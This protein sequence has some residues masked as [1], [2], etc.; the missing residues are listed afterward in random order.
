MW[1]GHEMLIHS[2]A[3]VRVR[4]D[5]VD[6]FAESERVSQGSL[7]QTGPSVHQS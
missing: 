5:A 6:N 7:G 3:L 1:E 2:G 4:R